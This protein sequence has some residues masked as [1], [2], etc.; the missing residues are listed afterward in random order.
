[1]TME[2]PGNKRSLRWDVLIHM[3]DHIRHRA[4]M[5]RRAVALCDQPRIAIE[6]ACREIVALGARLPNAVRRSAEAISSVTEIS[7][8]QSTVSAIG[9][10]LGFGRGGCHAAL[11]LISMIR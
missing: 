4:Q 10:T 7:V 5:A 8:F 11:L 1:M 3:L 6:Q 9:S 2:L